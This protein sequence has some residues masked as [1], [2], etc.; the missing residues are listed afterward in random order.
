MT[1]HTFSDLPQDDESSLPTMSNNESS[2]MTS[3]IDKDYVNAL[4]KKNANLAHSL[5]NNTAPNDSK[6][7]LTI[8][9]Y[10]NGFLTSN[11]YFYSYEDP[12]N[13]TL[14][15][16]LHDK[17]IPATIEEEL[18]NCSFDANL[19]VKVAVI[20]KEYESYEPLVINRMTSSAEHVDDQMFEGFNEFEK[21][22]KSEEMEMIIEEELECDEFEREEKEGL[23]KI[24]LRLRREKKREVVF[25]KGE[26]SIR[27]LYGVV[28]KVFGKEVLGEFGLKG[29]VPPKKMESNGVKIQ[30]VKL[31][32]GCIDIVM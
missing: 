17:V 30:D 25:V 7:N 13:K 28:R 6:N 16:Q 5:S 10:S 18:R 23:V 14:L 29:G 15:A 11:N 2:A 3:M 20:D 22:K 21:I 12:L 19:E 9:K 4:A 8:T 26:L 24:I 32:N 1:I 27:Q 31:L